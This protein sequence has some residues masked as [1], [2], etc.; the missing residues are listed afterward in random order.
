MRRDSSPNKV[1]DRKAEV[2]CFGF[3]FFL[4]FVEAC[5]LAAA[6]WSE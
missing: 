4:I 3:F 2:A 5:H 1:I 6:N